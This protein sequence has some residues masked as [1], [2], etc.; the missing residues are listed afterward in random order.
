MSGIAGIYHTDGRPVDSSLLY[1]MI[2]CV[3]HRG[4]DG[5]HV[6]AKGSVGLAHR[7]LCSTEESLRE[8][9][10]ASNPAKSCWITFDGRIDNREELISQ[11]GTN[12][13][14]T[15][16]ELML[17]SYE[18]WGTG[19][20]EYLIGDFAFALW[21]SSKQLLFCGRD[22]Y[23]IRPFYYHHAGSDFFF[24]SEVRQVI[25][26]PDLPMEINEEAIAEWLTAAGLHGLHYRD[27]RQSFFRGIWELPAAHYLT[28]DQHGLQVRRYWDWDTQ[29]E[30]HYRDQNQYFE[31]FSQIFH[32]AVRCRLR[33][34]GPVGAELS[35]GFDSSSVVCVAQ[36]LI[37]K[38]EGSRSALT[39][40]S[41]VFDELSCDE[42][43]LIQSVVEKY[44]IEF[45][46]IVADDLCGLLNLRS[47]DD[48]LRSIDRPDQFALEKAGEV[49]YQ[50]AHQRGV[51]VM[52]SGEGAENHV[53]GSEFVLDS[54]IRRLEWLELFRRFRVIQKGS[55]WR[56]SLGWS[57]RYGV[58]PLLPESLGS[59]LYFKWFHPEFDQEHF[60]SFY[61]PLLSSL[62]QKAHAQQ[63]E[64]L[65]RFPAARGWARRFEY[66][67][68]NPA[69]SLLRPFCQPVERRFPYHDRRLVAYCL[70]LPPEVKYQ[71]L[72]ESQRRY[73]RGRVLQKET[74]KGV[75][76]ETIR[77]VR[78]KVNFND[79]YRRRFAEAKEVLHGLFQPPVVPRIAEMGLLDTA[80]FWQRLSE[81]LRG[82]ENSEP[83]DPRIC[84]YV[85]RIIQLELWSQAL[86]TVARN[87]VPLTNCSSTRELVLTR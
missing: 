67:N 40:F 9:Q 64:R 42:R 31:E 86:R 70:A 3:P 66:E 72:L 34:R 53:M 14:F 30:V 15:D 57:V 36:E 39:A 52:L 87:R 54:L 47:N 81:V 68:L 8:V 41:M 33:S 84:L 85:N 13:R 62:T 27:M 26:N 76:P 19:C 61:T 28:F 77:Q 69:S 5:V 22:H 71:H 60:P 58:A 7:Q 21:D 38:G 73:V 44:K 46:P 82:F 11:L 83:V 6:Y 63:K 12:P 56:G 35:G 74:F 78:A 37:R 50:T 79:L 20:L 4:T 23:G 32:E 48:N 18:H 49:L 2:D 17:R 25:Q 24:G 51:R 16:V 43:P 45:C 55:S 1:R 80:R 29:K 59:K 75:L 65:E 10:P